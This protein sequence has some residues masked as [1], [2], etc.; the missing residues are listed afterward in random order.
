MSRVRIL[1]GLTVVKMW[2]KTCVKEASRSAKS[3]GCSVYGE[4]Y[5]VRTTEAGLQNNLQ[6][7][8]LVD[9]ILHET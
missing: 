4:S 5:T 1:V 6:K 9:S 2:V 8:M 7:R 3:S